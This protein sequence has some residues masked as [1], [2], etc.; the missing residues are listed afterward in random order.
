MGGQGAS[1]VEVESGIRLAVDV[2]NEGTL[3]LVL[4]QVVSSIET[5]TNIDPMSHPS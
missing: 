5:C 3:V 1:I 2:E 4:F